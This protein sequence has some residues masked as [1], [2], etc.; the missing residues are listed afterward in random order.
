ME[1]GV[2]FACIGSDG[3]TSIYLVRISS[4]SKWRGLLSLA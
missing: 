3:S 2:R 1:G 4:L